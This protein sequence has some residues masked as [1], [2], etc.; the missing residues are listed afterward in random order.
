MGLGSTAKKV[1]KLADLA[2]KLYSQVQ[3]V[4]DRVASLDEDLEATAERVEHVE[5]EQ[6][7][8]RALL[9]ALAEER[10]VD[11]DAVLDAADAPA[12][13]ERVGDSAAASAGGEPDE[14]G[15]AEGAD[16]EA[17]GQSVD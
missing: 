10:G 12:E 8:Q 1:Q 6:Q 11:V 7:R 5:A 9:E 4:R 15:A 2:E 3:D 16:G 17:P 13:G 14:S